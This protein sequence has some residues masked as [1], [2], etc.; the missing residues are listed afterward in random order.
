MLA[1]K[2]PQIIIQKNWNSCVITCMKYTETWTMFS[3]SISSDGMAED[4]EPA[5]L[6]FE[7]TN[8][9]IKIIVFTS[10]YHNNYP[11]V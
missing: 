2:M 1:L 4:N 11:T 6:R 8:E 10:T 7:L 5:S 3:F 9:K